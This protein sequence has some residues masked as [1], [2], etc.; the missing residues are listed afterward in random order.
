M[1][2][3]IPFRDPRACIDCGM[4][5]RFGDPRFFHDDGT[6]RCDGCHDEM[7]AVRARAIVAVR[8]A[9]RSGVLP[10]LDTQRCVDCEDEAEVY[11]HRDYSQP[12][13]VQPVCRRCNQRRGPAAWHRQPAPEADSAKA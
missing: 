11:E 1:G 12:L 10:A 9:I 4:S 7:S 2:R 3:Y 5:I 8:K 6:L 13:R